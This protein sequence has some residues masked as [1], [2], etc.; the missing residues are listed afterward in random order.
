MKNIII[1]ALV[2]G[3]WM[4][5]FWFNSVLWAKND[6]LKAQIDPVINEGHRYT[7]EYETSK[8]NKK[9]L[10][11]QSGF[12][13]TWPEGD[14]FECIKG[15]TVCHICAKNDP[16]VPAWKT[17]S[18]DLD[19]TPWIEKCEK[20]TPPLAWV[21]VPSYSSYWLS[22]AWCTEKPVMVPCGSGQTQKT[23]DNKDYCC[24]SAANTPATWATAWAACDK[25]MN[26]KLAWKSNAI[27]S[28]SG[29]WCV[30]KPGFKNVNNEC[31]PCN[32]EWVCC[33]I[34]L[35]TNVPFIGKCIEDGSVENLSPDETKVTSSTA[36]PVLMWSLTKILVTIILIVS[37]VLIIIGGIMIATGD[38]GWGKKMIMKVVVGIALLGASGVILRLINPNFFG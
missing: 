12:H 5:F 35:N 7:C 38:P 8:Q 24:S 23:C 27:V 20:Q 4:M 32:A 6:C 37:F 11:C 34:E 33:G 10:S 22:C 9:Y 2:C 28:K 3:I 25:T 13:D 1:V 36:F 18:T 30:C 31:K 19:C 15:L 26:S 17:C 16:V 14:G 21:C 29:I